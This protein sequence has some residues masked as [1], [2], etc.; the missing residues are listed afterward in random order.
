MTHHVSWISVTLNFSY[1]CIDYPRQGGHVFDPCL[2][3]WL[4]CRLVG[5][6]L[7]WLLDWLVAC[8][9]GWLVGWFFAKFWWRMGLVDPDQRTDPSF[10]S[11][12]VH[13]CKIALPFWQWCSFLWEQHL[14]LDEKGKNQVYS[15]S[16]YKRGLVGPWWLMRCT[17]FHPSV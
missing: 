5:W 2:Y 7:D 14:V 10:L 12:F 8:L 6:L 4:A 1:N 16:E 13:H 9:I 3:C 17:E 15:I 11:K